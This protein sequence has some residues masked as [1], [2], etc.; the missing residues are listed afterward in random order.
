MFRDKYVYKTLNIVL[1]FTQIVCNKDKCIWMIFKA[2]QNE[3]H[4]LNYTY[5]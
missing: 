2:N 1:K 3:T 5:L 4:F